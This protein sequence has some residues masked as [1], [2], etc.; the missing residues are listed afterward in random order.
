[1]KHGVRGSVSAFRLVPYMFLV[2]GFIA[3]N[4]NLL[5]EIWIYLPSLL[6]GI[7]A[8]SVVSKDITS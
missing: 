3:L 2:L 1:M 6:V 5:L 8:G 7:I 4:N